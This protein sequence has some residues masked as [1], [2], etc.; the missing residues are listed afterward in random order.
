MGV[1]TVLLL[2]VGAWG[3]LASGAALATNIAQVALVKATF[4]HAMSVRATVTVPNHGAGQ[5]VTLTGAAAGTMIST[6]ELALSQVFTPP[7]VQQEMIGLRGAVSDEAR[8][9]LLVTGAGASEVAFKQVSV[10][11]SRAT[12]HA[13]VTAWSE[14]SIRQSPSSTPISSRPTNVLDATAHL[15]QDTTDRW[16]VSSFTWAF[17]PGEGP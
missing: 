16:R 15:T 11:G 3:T 5:K 10:D 14:L 6:G 7:A 13:H 8:G 2:G 17:V 4:E 1:A 9:G 12:V